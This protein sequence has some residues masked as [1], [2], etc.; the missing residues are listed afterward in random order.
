MVL[1]AV[2][3]DLEYT[4]TASHVNFQL[5]GIESD[6][7]ALFVKTW[8]SDNDIPLIEL[9]ADTKKYADEKKLNIQSA[10][11]EIRYNWWQDLVKKGDYDFVAT[12]HHRDDA[13]E[14]V[15][16]NLLRGTGIKGLTGIPVKRDYFIRPLI[17][18]SRADIEDFAAHHNIPFRTDSSNETDDYHRNRIRHHLIPFVKEFIAGPETFME[19][20]LHRIRAEWDTWEYYYKEWLN[21]HVIPS[22][23][24]YS[25]QVSSKDHAFLL[26]WLEE[27][28]IPWPLAYDYVKAPSAETGKVLNYGDFQ[29]SR[30]SDG[31]YLEKNDPVASVSIDKPGIYDLEF[32]E[33]LM[34]EVD[35]GEFEINND[36]FTE[37]INPEAIQWPIQIRNVEP[38]DSFQPLGM[39]GKTKKLQD[40]LVD[41]KLE[42]FEKRQT[43]V[44]TSGGKIVWVIGI[45]LD[46]RFKVLN[47]H[48]QAYKLKFRRKDGQDRRLSQSE[49]DHK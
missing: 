27:K 6:G 32:G 18:V 41:L 25:I 5:R 10:A 37:Y 16:I 39:E 12:A 28:S 7:D 42:N 31:F 33:F 40:L 49:N 48:Q 34:I 23:E 20:T 30:T 14:T 29:L 2:L 1:L 44:L 45:R 26:K 36:P 19:Q 3:K 21:A 11:R 4:V 47:Q 46:E 38:G 9:N 22:G 8:C 35:D 17:E 43:K 24:N 15:F 13:I